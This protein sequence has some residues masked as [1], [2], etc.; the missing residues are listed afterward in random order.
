MWQAAV[1]ILLL[2]LLLFLSLKLLLYVYCRSLVWLLAYL[3][4]C[5]LIRSFICSSRFF[6]V[7][8]FCRRFRCRR[9]RRRRCSLLAFAFTWL[10]H[11]TYRAAVCCHCRVCIIVKINKKIVVVAFCYCVVADFILIIF[12]MMCAC[13]CAFV[14]FLC[15]RV[16]AS[17]LWSVIT[18]HTFYFVVVVDIVIFC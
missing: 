16:C 11:S 12:Y 10:L 1:S 14:Q 6:S 15:V 7:L 3:F 9:R 17:L 4:V 5:S 2:L 18:L 13:V 8:Y